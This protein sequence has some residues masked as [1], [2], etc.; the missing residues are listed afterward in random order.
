MKLSDDQS[1]FVGPVHLWAIRRPRQVVGVAVA[2]VLVVVAAVVVA[3]QPRPVITLDSGWGMGPNYY[4]G[5][6]GFILTGGTLTNRGG[7]DGYA[8]VNWVIGRA[9]VQ[10]VRYQVPAHQS[11]NILLT[12][13]VYLGMDTSASYLVLLSVQPA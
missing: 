4:V 7:A 2:T 3:V 6:P 5:G 10:Q 8:V 13:P 11:F 12:Q 1:R 9:V